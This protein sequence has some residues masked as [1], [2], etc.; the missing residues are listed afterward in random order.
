[1]V[2][3]RTEFMN[4]VYFVGGW[5]YYDATF[6]LVTRLDFEVATLVVVLVSAIAAMPLSIWSRSTSESSLKKIFLGALDAF[7]AGATASNKLSWALSDDVDGLVSCMS[8]VFT[9]ESS[10][11]GAARLVDT[12]GTRTLLTTFFFFGGWPSCSST[13]IATASW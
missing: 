2:H 3:Q 7:G 10:V 5:Y 6:F 8:V 11:V 1:M 9:D 4:V 13:G 12:F